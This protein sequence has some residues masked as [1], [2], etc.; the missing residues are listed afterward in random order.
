MGV[1][2]HCESPFVGFWVEKVLSE[3]IPLNYSQYLTEWVD[4]AFCVGCGVHAA[5]AANHE[6]VI[7]LLAQALQC[8]AHGGLAEIEAV[9]RLGNAAVL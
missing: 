4:Q 3:N 5:G 6:L 2:A 9:S 1:D 7:E 8:V